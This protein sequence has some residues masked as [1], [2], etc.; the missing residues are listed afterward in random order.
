[1]V[2]RGRGRKDKLNETQNVRE[3]FDDGSDE[4]KLG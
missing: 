4:E 3:L 2:R 1:V